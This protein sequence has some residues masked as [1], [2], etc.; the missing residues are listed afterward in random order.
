M[1]ASLKEETFGHQYRLAIEPPKDNHPTDSLVNLSLKDF[2]GATS[3]TEGAR[4]RI[5][6]KSPRAK[7]HR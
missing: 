1:S 5:V 3:P 2:L 4:A 6:P 7:Q